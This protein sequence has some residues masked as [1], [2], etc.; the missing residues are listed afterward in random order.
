MKYNRE[1]K[2][3]QQKIYKISSNNKQQ[4]KNHKILPEFEK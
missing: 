4:N 1:T 3:N 2:Y